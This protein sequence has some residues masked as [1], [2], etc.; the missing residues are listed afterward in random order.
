MNKKILIVDDDKATLLALTI[1][2]DDNGFSSTGA[3]TGRDAIEFFK[4]GVFDAVLLD[5]KMP[6]MDGINIMYELKKVSHDVP[7]IIL[8]GHADIQIAVQSIKLGAYDFI[9][10]PPD[11]NNLAITLKRG[12]ERTELERAVRRLNTAVG[13]HL[14]GLLGSGNAI[15]KVIEQIHQVAESNFSV[16]V[17]GETGAGKSIVARAIHNISKRAA[18]PFITVDIGTIPETLIESEIFGH[19]KGAF[20]G[21]EKSKKG[22]FEISHG[23]TILLDELENISPY[24]QTKLLRLVEEKKVYPLGSTKSIEVDVRI[25]AAT[26]RDINQ[27]VKEKKF[28]EDLFYRLG[29]FIITIPPLRERIGD[30]PFFAHKFL[31][32]AAEELKK[33]YELTEDAEAFLKRHHW[34]GNIRELKNVIRRSA[35]V[36][37]RGV[38]RRENLELL[39]ADKDKDAGGLSMIPLKEVAAI[40][41]RSAE[42]KAIR[43]AM[44]LTKGNKTKA[45][46]IL[47]IDYKT[48]LKKIKDYGI[49]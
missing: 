34:P 7:I 35:L 47:Q 21:A 42:E 24:I 11:F 23:G 46:A 36:S 8:T 28:R 13:I 44:E 26:N 15:K 1:F 20:T 14:E 25:I 2:L 45:A 12:I 19:E 48:L 3:Y 27:D 49:N 38:I 39:I 22:F 40:A 10:K 32:E 31:G 4:R 30:I 33:D 29:E 9:K 17:Q 43:H 5:L 41:T 6:D 37:T 18:A 16:I